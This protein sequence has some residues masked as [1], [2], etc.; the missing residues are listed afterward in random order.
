MN[1]DFRFKDIFKRNILDIEFKDRGIVE[2]FI[3][4]ILNEDLAYNIKIRVS[5]DEAV[6]NRAINR[7][8]RI[9]L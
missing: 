6:R 1:Y 3:E 5:K 8:K 2:Y 4:S 7:L 9:L